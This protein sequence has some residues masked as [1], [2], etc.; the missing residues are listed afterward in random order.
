MESNV[1]EQLP[2][3][4]FV[5]GE[6]ALAV[7]RKGRGTQECVVVD[8]LANREVEPGQR[9]LAY[10]VEIPGRQSPAFDGCW[11]A[12]PWQ[13]IKLKPPEDDQQDEFTRE[14]E[15]VCPTL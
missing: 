8:G 10:I 15:D 13:L 3:D 2:S 4:Q 7:S 5:V 6:R 9:G 1:A 12:Y 14:L 11:N